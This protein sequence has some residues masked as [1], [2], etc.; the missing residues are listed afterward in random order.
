M[1]NYDKLF[2]PFT[3][4]AMTLRNRIVM[5]PM[6]TRFATRDGSVTQK[7]IDYYTARGRGGAGLIIT[8]GAYMDTKASIITHC[9]LG[10]YDDNHIAGLNELAESVQATGAKIALQL[11]HAGMQKFTGKRP[12]VAPSAIAWGKIGIVPTELSVSETE[13]II[14]SFAEACNRAKKAGFDAVEIHGG[15]GYLVS[16]FMSPHT[17]QRTDKYGGTFER[18]MN[19][20]LELMDRIRTFIGDEFPIGFRISADEF[21]AHGNTIEDTKK[22]IK[23]LENAGISWV[24]ASAGV[25]DTIDR[26]VPPMYLPAG[27]NVYLAKEFKKEVKIPVITVGAINDPQL[28]ND[29]IRRDDADLVA[30]GRA[31]L[32]DPDL[33]NKALRGTVDD[34]RKCIRC[35]DGCNARS[36]ENKQIRCSINAEA[37]HEDTFRLKPTDE[38][39]NI[40]VIGSGPAG[41]EAAR[42]ATT[43]GHRVTLLDKGDRLGGQLLVA[44][45]PSF[46]AD[47]RSF[48]QYL[49]TQVRKLGVTIELNKEVTIEDIRKLKPDAVILTTGA[50][51]FIPEIK[52]IKG[53]IVSTATEVL[54]GKEVGENTI[55][56]GGNMV[57]CEVAIF[58]GEKGKNVTILE[59]MPEIA[60]DIEPASKIVVKK[61]FKEYHVSCR[62]NVKLE[63]ITN[64]GAVTIDRDWNRE[65]HKADSVVLA[66][67]FTAENSL[68]PKLKTLGIEAHNI[69]DSREPRNILEAVKEGDYI[70][71]TI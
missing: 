45:I 6:V 32:A 7:I 48:V 51:H 68:L 69:G 26:Q 63:E 54:C 5:S 59:M 34:I 9:Q 13:E 19:F 3:V 33:P 4:G 50:R 12:I 62:T 47:I 1:G 53:S 17:N 21:L 58:L 65:F 67:G 42:L 35:N 30:M 71:R 43:R 52:G 70:G 20:P 25:H 22:M 15:H 36:F 55:V 11:I 56:A 8:G 60:P 40:L 37:G 41:M 31:L 16:A 39:K 10:V 49:E 27:C 46:K 61:K 66:L 57:G 14:D 64:T 38:P 23:Y 18:R 2:E 29:V 24:H 28:A 44:S